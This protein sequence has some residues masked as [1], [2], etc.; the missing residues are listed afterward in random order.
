MKKEINLLELHNPVNKRN[1]KMVKQVTRLRNR[2]INELAMKSVLAIGSGLFV[3][4]LGAL[5]N[6]LGVELSSD[7][8]NSLVANP[9]VLNY[10]SYAFYGVGGTVIGYSC[11]TSYERSKKI[12]E[13]KRE[14]EKIKE[15][16]KPKTITTEQ[17]KK[18]KS[19]RLE[20]I[21]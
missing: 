15:F 11:K 14:K 19:I 2:E 13:L 6:K 9:N 10:F 8:L 18:L 17:R 20:R 7:E 4:G 3:I 1:R 5:I 16:Y 12:K 21:G